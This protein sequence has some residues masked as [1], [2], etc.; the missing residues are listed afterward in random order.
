M[1][2]VPDH[3]QTVSGPAPVSLN[4]V[5]QLCDVYVQHIRPSFGSHLPPNLL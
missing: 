3:K 4:E 1:M 2:L 5:Q